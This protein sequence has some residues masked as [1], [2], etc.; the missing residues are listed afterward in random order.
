MAGA[1]PSRFAP[2]APE[3]GSVE[4]IARF[5]TDAR[6]VSPWVAYV[7]ASSMVPSPTRHLGHVAGAAGELTHAARI[8]AYLRELARTSPR[9][10][11]EA[12]GQIGRAHV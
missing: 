12:I 1:A 3:A 10:H 9:V 4:A 7:P 6:F 2:D 5:T 8:Q 11:V